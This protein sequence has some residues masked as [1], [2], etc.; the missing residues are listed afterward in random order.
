M[1]VRK[2]WGLVC[3]ELRECTKAAQY[4]LSGSCAEKYPEMD[5]AP[6]GQSQSFWR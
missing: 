5:I 3:N 2:G 4:L 6:C 1:R